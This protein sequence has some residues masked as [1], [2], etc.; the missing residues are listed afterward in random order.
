MEHRGE[1]AFVIEVVGPSRAC[2]LRGHARRRPSAHRGV[3]A[4]RRRAPAPW[5]RASCK[6]RTPS[7]WAARSSW[8]RP[9]SSSRWYS[10]RRA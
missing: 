6:R 4:S 8:R 3:T 7:T 2:S 10:A 1:P 9:C 5:A